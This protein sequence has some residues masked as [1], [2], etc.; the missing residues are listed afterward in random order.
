[1]AS[2]KAKRNLEL[3]HDYYEKTDQYNHPMNEF[4][5]FEIIKKTILSDNEL[6]TEI[7]D[8]S[9]LE[10]LRDAKLFFKTIYSNNMLVQMP[11]YSMLY[12]IAST[13]SEVTDSDG[14]LGKYVVLMNLIKSKYLSGKNL[15]WDESKYVDCYSYFGLDAILGNACCRHRASL[16]KDAIKENV[17]VKRIGIGDSKDGC[18][19]H[20]II[21]AYSKELKKYLFLDPVSFKIYNP[22]DKLELKT[23]S[24][25]TKYIKA[26]YSTTF[27][28]EFDDINSFAKF[29]N[30]IYKSQLT[31][32]EIDETKVRLMLHSLGDSKR[33]EE[34]FTELS[35]IIE[36]EREHVKRLIKISGGAQ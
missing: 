13:V 34:A 26:N 12:N 23:E 28:D 6:L 5:F 31:D 35:K 20:A 7:N 10:M 32:D 11:Y 36:P 4:D 2:E 29:F 19:N 17:D 3:L 24:G 33:K 30:N 22:N 14:I 18:A 16:I 21:A 1:M 8:E 27:F 25:K 15:T 9:Y